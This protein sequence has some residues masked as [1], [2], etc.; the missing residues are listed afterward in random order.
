VRLWLRDGHVD[1]G[2][3]TGV[4]GDRTIELTAQARKLLDV[5]VRAGGAEV[6]ADDLALL[7]WGARHVGADARHQAIARLRREVEVDP[8]APWHV[9]AEGGSYRWRSAPAPAPRP[10]RV[11][12]L[13]PEARA[14]AFLDRPGQPCSLVGPFGSG[15][16]QLAEAALEAL[17]DRVAVAR[18]DCRLLDQSEILKP[19]YVVNQIRRALADVLPELGE[20]RCE[21]AL[22]LSHALRR[23]LD[24]TPGAVVLFLDDAERLRHPGCPL[25][26][27][28]SLRSLAQSLPALR[29]LLTLGADPASLVPDPRFSAFA[30]APPIYVGG[31]TLDEACALAELLGV[32]SND[33]VASLVADIGSLPLDLAAVLREASAEGWDEAMRR[34]DGPSG[35]L[36]HRWQVLD[37]TLDDPDAVATLRAAV[38]GKVLQG[39]T[40]RRM[41]VSG[42]LVEGRTGPCVA[43]PWLA[44]TLASRL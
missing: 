41:L 15:R 42:L 14:R 3:G 39:P 7:V 23:A 13:G 12:R 8:A 38:K 26:V 11:A 30:L 36:S 33:R 2:S 5:L 4:R 6:P 17:G 44:R 25:S 29:L 43:T 10:E 21:D 27:F 19:S 34:L 24:R 20:H 16:T 28:A 32:R 40:Y 31:L 22:D 1:L 18:M 35:I 37:Q 9:L